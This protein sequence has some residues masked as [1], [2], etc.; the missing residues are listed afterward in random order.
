MQAILAHLARS[1]A[2]SHP[3]PP[4]SPPRHEGIGNVTPADVYH[5]RR[6][7]ILWQRAAQKR[8]TLARRVRYHRA[9][10]MQGTRGELTGDLSV[11]RSLTESQRC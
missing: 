11:P 5:G 1:G 10:A 8:R 6:D 7:A 9:A 2:P 3:A 4:P